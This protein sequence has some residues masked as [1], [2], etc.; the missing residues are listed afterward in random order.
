M[1]HQS[2]QLGALTV[3]PVLLVVAVRTCQGRHDVH[4]DTMR[5]LDG[6]G[7]PVTGHP[8]AVL[9]LTPQLSARRQVAAGDLVITSG[10]RS[11]FSEGIAIGT[12]ETIQGKSYET[13]LELQ[14][15]PIVD[16]GR[17][18]YVFVLKEAE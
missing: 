16:F 1:N 9:G 8:D 3:W 12:V 10:M 17:L 5:L 13:S 7:V 15:R 2:L 4:L 18:E 14:L 6:V 11:I